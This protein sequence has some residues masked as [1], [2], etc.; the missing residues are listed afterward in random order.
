MSNYA[1][2]DELTFFAQAKKR[3]R[4]FFGRKSLVSLRDH[5]SGMVYA[6]SACGH[7]DALKLFTAFVKSYNDKLFLT[8]RNGYVCWWNHLLYIS[9]GMDDLAFDSFYR[10]FEA[11]LSREHNLMLPKVE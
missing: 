4:M 9:G 7:P 3:P 1:E 5:L 10:R 6:F 8:D 2:F 11:Y